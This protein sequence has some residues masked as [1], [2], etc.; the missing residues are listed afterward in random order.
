MRIEVAGVRARV[1]A[2]LRKITP[3]PCER[4]CARGLT[5]GQAAS[6]HVHRAA[7]HKSGH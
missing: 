6:V 2:R 5:S 3:K 4:A 1:H 7:E